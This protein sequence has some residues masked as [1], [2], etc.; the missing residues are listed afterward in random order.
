[1]T[2]DELLSAIT[3]ELTAIGA[4]TDLGIKSQ[5]G[6]RISAI[7]LFEDRQFCLSLEPAH[8]DTDQVAGKIPAHAAR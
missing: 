6:E 7:L 2:A 3:A 1:M 5:D 4:A 8:I